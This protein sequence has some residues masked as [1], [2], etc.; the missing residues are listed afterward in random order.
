MDGWIR[1][2]DL[3]ISVDDLGF[4]QGVTVVERLRT[5]GG[6]AFEPT[7][8]LRRFQRGLDQL[9]ICAPMSTTRL[10]RLIRACLDRNRALVDAEGDVGVTLCATP[11]RAGG[12]GSASSP[13][14]LVHLNP[15]DHALTRSRLSHGQTLVTTAVTQQAETTWPRSIK[16]R[17]R[18]HYYLADQQ[19]RVHADAS[20]VS[21]I[22]IDHDGSI[23]ET[24]ISNILIVMDDAV[25]SPLPSQVL[26]GVTQEVVEEIAFRA[27]IPWRYARIQPAQLLT[28]D[29][30]LLTGTDHGIWW[31]NEVDGR[32]FAAP[33]RGGA[34]ERLISLFRDSVAEAT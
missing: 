28:A 11:G 1:K 30:V 33:A 6:V 16:V 3:A 32:G 2:R 24:S 29:A 12:P 4:R 10:S 5:Y 17:S 22:L 21:G 9:G 7:R 20:D 25:V 27:Q 13:T 26:P 31:A 19:A 8:Y 14:L 18:L 23:T 34:G 15:I